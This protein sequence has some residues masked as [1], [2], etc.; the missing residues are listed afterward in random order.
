MTPVAEIP[1]INERRFTPGVTASQGPPAKVAGRHPLRSPAAS[2]PAAAGG[3][4]RGSSYRPIRSHHFPEVMTSQPPKPPTQ[5]AELGVLTSGPYLC[6]FDVLLSG[7][8]A[9]LSLHT[10]LRL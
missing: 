4:A 2:S 6:V 7:A 9:H 3:D 1:F 10:M 5:T 8:P